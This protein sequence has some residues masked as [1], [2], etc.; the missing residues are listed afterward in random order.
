MDGDLSGYFDN[1]IFEDNTFNGTVDLKSGKD[2]KIIS[3]HFISGGS[4]AFYNFNDS[5]IGSNTFDNSD[6]YFSGN[7]LDISEKEAKK[8]GLRVFNTD[9]N[10]DN[11]INNAIKYLI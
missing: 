10:F 7:N 9:V 1:V 6:I 5:E 3:N 4:Y 8:F 11:Q 2:S